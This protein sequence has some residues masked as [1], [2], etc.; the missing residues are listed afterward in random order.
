LL[1]ILLALLGICL[2]AGTISALRH[3][4]AFRLAI[5]NIP[6][7][8]TQSALIVLGLMLATLL[9]SASFATGDTLTGSLREDALRT[10][11]GVDLLLRGEAGNGQPLPYFDADLAAETEQILVADPEVEAVMPAIVETAAVFAPTSGLSEPRVDLVGLPAS[12]AAGFASPQDNRGHAFGLDALAEG[13]ALISEQ[14][15][16][17]LA[18][19]KGDRVQV[20][21][22]PQPVELTV[23][24]VFGRGA[25][26]AGLRSLVLGLPALGR[27]TGHDGEI[28]RI[29]I[30][31]TGPDPKAAGHAAAV[32]AL[33]EDFLS[34]HSLTAEGVKQRALDESEQAG[35]TFSSIFLLFA[36]FSVAAGVLLIFLIFVMLAAER[37]HELGIAR[38]V[39]AQRGHVIRMFAYEGALYALVAGAV[40]SFLG[41]LVGWVMVRVLGVAFRQ[42]GPEGDF[43]LAFSVNLRSLLIAFCLGVVFTFV[44][45]SPSRGSCAKVGSAW[46]VNSPWSSWGSFSR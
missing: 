3:R 27:L 15:A 18:V 1:L 34:R 12:P 23:G 7:R 24:G 14:A 30:S 8:K 21:L 5:R 10:V 36:Q 37:K 35:A 22:G 46:W 16:D 25:E 20:F 45:M 44:A 43:R 42:V 26:P 11:G 17:R 40:G 29:L 38:A 9:F 19:R 33:L 28:N 39:G 6:R 32:E 2:A 13:E 4:V 41:A 31:N